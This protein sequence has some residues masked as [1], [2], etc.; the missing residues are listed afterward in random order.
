M[1]VIDKNKQREQTAPPPEIAEQW[2]RVRALED[3]WRRLRQVIAERAASAEMQGVPG[4]TT[5]LLTH[6]VKGIG[7]GDHFQAVDEYAVDT[8]LLRELREIEK[9]AAQE[10]GQWTEKHE[11]TGADGGP[12]SLEPAVEELRKLPIDELIRLHREALGALAE[13]G[14]E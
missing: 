4:G 5:G 8:N 10:L 12:I 7:S 13:I 11:H 2:E 1:K 9:Q 14:E 6:T 3:R